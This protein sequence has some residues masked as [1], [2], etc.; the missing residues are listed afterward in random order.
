MGSSEIVTDLVAWGAKS[1]LNGAGAVG[2]EVDGRR[3]LP[4]PR[5]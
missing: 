2:S 1:V 3:R 5:P 4:A